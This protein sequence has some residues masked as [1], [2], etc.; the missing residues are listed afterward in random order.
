MARTVAQALAAVRNTTG[1]VAGQRMSDAEGCGYVVDAYNAIKNERP[2][3]FLGNWAEIETAATTDALLVPAQFFRPLVDYVI[4]RA[5]SKD[6]AHV[7]SARADLMFKLA[8]SY[9]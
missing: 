1:D 4:A 5:E 9:L 6:A 3:L 2:D 8:G 7:V